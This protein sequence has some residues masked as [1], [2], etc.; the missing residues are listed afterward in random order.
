MKAPSQKFPK[1][2]TIIRDLLAVWDPEVSVLATKYLKKQTKPRRSPGYGPLMAYREFSILAA[3]T[4]Q[5]EVARRAFELHLERIDFYGAMH[6]QVAMILAT[7]QW[8]ATELNLAGYAD[9]FNI[10]IPEDYETRHRL[11]RDFH[12]RVGPR[13]V[14]GFGAWGTIS[15]P[16]PWWKDTIDAGI[17]TACRDIQFLSSYRRYPPGNDLGWAP[18]DFSVRTDE[19][20]RFLRARFNL[21]LEKPYLPEDRRVRLPEGFTEFPGYRDLPQTA[22][23]LNLDRAIVENHQPTPEPA[24]TEES[25]L[26]EKPVASED[27]RTIAQLLDGLISA[28]RLTPNPPA[29]PEE[30]GDLQRKLGVDLPEDYRTTLLAHNGTDDREFCSISETLETI[31]EFHDLAD[32]FPFP[33]GYNISGET[34]KTQPGFFVNGWVPF[35]DHGTG[36]FDCLDCNPGPNGQHGQIIYLSTDGQSSVTYG[37]YKEWLIDNLQ[38]TEDLNDVGDD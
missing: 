1:D 9:L 24:A 7:H 4:G 18:E 32:D 29:T 38:E 26:D 35:Y 33:E 3:V 30:I 13:D 31:E 22:V 19:I 36:D 10:T 37:S 21:P 28:Q 2:K 8:V 15:E 6:W 20:I 5:P 17:A 23:P 27:S 12:Q 14:I 11:S 34:G 25:F 16:T